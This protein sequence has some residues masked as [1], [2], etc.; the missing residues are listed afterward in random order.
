MHD[1]TPAHE[2]L[3]YV[4]RLRVSAGDDAQPVVH[5]HRAPAYSAMDAVVQAFFS[6]TGRAPDDGKVVVEDVR[7]DINAYRTFRPQRK[8]K[9]NG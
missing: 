4:V 8:V 1:V 9:V 5:E 2:P 3:P 6:A 7:P